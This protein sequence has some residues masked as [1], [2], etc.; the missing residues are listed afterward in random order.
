MWLEIAIASI[1][2]SVGSIVFGRFE[3]GTPTWR[4]L[5]K[6]ALFLGITALVAATAG[7]PWALGWIAFLFVLGTG[8]HFWWCGKNGIDPWK[9][10][11]WER[12]RELRGWR[13]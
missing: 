2:F 11:P 12:Y 10:E 7:R 9:A 5:L 6:F 13:S 4:R 1:L 8:F 3:S